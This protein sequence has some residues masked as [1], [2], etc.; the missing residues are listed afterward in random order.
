LK[1][2]VEVIEMFKKENMPIGD[3]IHLSCSVWSVAWKAQPKRSIVAWKLLFSKQPWHYILEFNWSPL[4]ACHLLVSHIKLI[5]HTQIYRSFWK[6]KLEKHISRNRSMW[7]LSIINMKKLCW[8]FKQINYNFKHTICMTC[9]N[10]QHDHLRW[11]WQ[12]KNFV[13]SW[14]WISTKKGI[15]I[16]SLQ[17][18]HTK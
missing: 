9:D 4:L 12:V 16:C 17:T 13:R 10:A 18:R 6:W 7:N 11:M 3:T 15:N 2:L 8:G 5:L 1:F 14:P